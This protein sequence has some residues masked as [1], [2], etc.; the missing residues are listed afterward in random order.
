MGGGDGTRRGG[1]RMILPAGAVGGIDILAALRPSGIASVTYTGRK[2]P[3]AWA[4]TPAEGLLDLAALTDEA[5]FF[6]GTAREAA[7]QYPKNANVAATVALAGA[8]LEA[9]RV[10]LIADPAISANVH[11]IAVQAG[12]AEFTIR[13]TGHPS[14]DNPKTSLTTVYSVAREILNRSREVAI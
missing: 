12:A 2:P 11:E 13:I 7:L 14:P 4:G 6:S 8:G 3:R 10:R 1:A 5:V 9:T